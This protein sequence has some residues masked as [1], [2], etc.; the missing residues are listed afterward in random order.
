[1]CC[2]ISQ[3]IVQRLKPSPAFDNT[4]A[5]NGKLWLINISRSFLCKE[6]A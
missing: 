2:R 3:E 5:N 1:M 6:V 4:I